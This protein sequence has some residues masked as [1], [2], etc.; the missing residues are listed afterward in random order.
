VNIPS[1]IWCY[2]TIKTLIISVGGL[3][4]GQLRRF[5]ENVGFGNL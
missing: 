2:L 5:L 1:P 4:K 3:E